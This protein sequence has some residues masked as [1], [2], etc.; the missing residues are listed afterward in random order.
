MR[1]LNIKNIIKRIRCKHDYTF[2]RNI[3]G[4]EIL[5]TKNYQRG[6]CKCKYCGKEIYSGLNGEG[7]THRINN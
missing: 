2:Y 6:I 7:I 5:H 3:Y 1:V 4:A